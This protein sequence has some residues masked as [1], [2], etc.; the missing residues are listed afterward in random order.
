VEEIP[1]ILDI[2]ID[3]NIVVETTEKFSQGDFTN[4][5]LAL[6]ESGAEITDFEVVGRKVSLVFKS[7]DEGNVKK[8]SGAVADFVAEYLKKK[9]SD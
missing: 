9:P 6:I 1:I 5:Q 4:L 8:V 3:S 7:E 2:A